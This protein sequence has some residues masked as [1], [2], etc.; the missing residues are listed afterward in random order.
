MFIKELELIN[1]R[2]YLNLKIEF[3]KGLNVLYGQ[4]AQGKT[5]VLEAINFISTLKSHRTSKDR[6]LIKW[7][8]SKAYIKANLN[9]SL[10]DF[11]V[12][13]LISEMSKKEA[14]LNG[15]KLSRASE[16]IGN[17]NTVIFSPEDLRLLKDGPDIRRRFID[18][19]LN[20]IKPRYNYYLSLYNKVLLERNNLIKKGIDKSL[21]DV[22]DQQLAEYGSFLI[23]N[24]IEFIKKLSIICKLLHRKI[25]NGNEELVIKY[26]GD[27]IDGELKSIKERLYSLYKNSIEEDIKKGYTSKGPQRDDIEVFINGVDAKH[28]AS[29]GQQRTAALSLKLS[30]IEI[31]KGE[32]GEYPILLLDD[33]MSE[34]D[35]QRQKYLLDS[36]M[37]VQIILTITSLNDLEKFSINRKRIF[38]VSN[39]NIQIKEF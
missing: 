24:R 32:T 2:N 12:E 15:I 34:L 5:N 22:Y 20:Q 7:G 13:V 30:E 33:V 36:L 4:N 27:I 23:F 9:K 39:G 6:E 10:G 25:T 19:E 3:L 35:L 11:T 28:Y 26:K 38:E 17:A 1:F 29:Q 37:D 14:K 8:K 31:I 18:N 16:V 21:L